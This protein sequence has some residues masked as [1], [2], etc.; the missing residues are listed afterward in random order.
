M[1]AA[2]SSAA[3]SS[4][5]VGSGQTLFLNPGVSTNVQSIVSDFKNFTCN[6]SNMI[7]DGNNGEINY[8]NSILS[9]LNLMNINQPFSE[10]I[11]DLLDQSWNNTD[12]IEHNGFQILRLPKSAELLKRFIAPMYLQMKNRSVTS[13]TE[14]KIMLGPVYATIPPADE[15]LLVAELDIPSSVKSNWDD[16]VQ[17]VRDAM[18]KAG[19]S[20]NVGL[21]FDD[22][23]T[24]KALNQQN[25][26]VLIGKP[27]ALQLAVKN[28]YA[29]PAVRATPLPAFA[30][31]SNPYRLVGGSARNLHAPLYPQ[32]VMN[33]G[34]HPFATMSG[35]ANENVAVVKA[36]IDALKAQSRALGLAENNAVLNQVDNYVNTLSSSLDSLNKDLL[37]LQ[38]SYSYI[39]THPLSAGLNNNLD[40]DQL[41]KLAAKSREIT[42]KS[43]RLSNQWN[44]LSKMEELLQEL[45]NSV[46]PRPTN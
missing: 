28:A 16:C 1:S 23:N 43:M 29:V 21:V 6:A 19:G 18:A 10:L 17:K 3:A 31:S 8:I 26:T 24:I 33:G 30:I 20:T 27:V 45:V 15:D 14:R 12:Y 38:D 39:A 32:L 4:S 2:S 5:G 41:E 34:A 37:T 22:K 35:G 11:R 9:A 42:E 44:K 7:I 25:V 40:K 36:R 13:V 46:K